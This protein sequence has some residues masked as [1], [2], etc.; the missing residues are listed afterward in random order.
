VLSTYAAI[1]AAGTAPGQLTVG[2]M[3]SDFGAERV[4]ET[5]R[6]YGLLGPRTE[7]DRLRDYNRWFGEAGFDGVAVPFLAGEGAAEIVSAYRELPVSGWHVHGFELQSDVV[8]VL[9]ELR[10]SSGRANAIVR[11]A[12]GALHG[13]WVESPREQF[14]VWRGAVAAL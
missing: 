2:E 6:V 9:D 3:R 1:D 10:S 13:C 4:R 12:D 14:E 5:T 8:P 11:S 7:T